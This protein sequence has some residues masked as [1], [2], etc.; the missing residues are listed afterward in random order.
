MGNLGSYQT[1]VKLAKKVG[2]PLVLGAT[3]AVGG[4]VIEHSAEA[5]GKAV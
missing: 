3:T 2:G 1:M 4:W 5:G